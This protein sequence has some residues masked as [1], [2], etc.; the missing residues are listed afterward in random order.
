MPKPDRTTY[1]RNAARVKALTSSGAST[2]E[3]AEELGCSTSTAARC[4]QSAQ[5]DLDVSPQTGER[6]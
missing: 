2:R 1:E 3:I 6:A 4:K 5:E